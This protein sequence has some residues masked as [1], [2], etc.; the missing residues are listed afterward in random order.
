[1]AD[2]KEKVID[3]H[4]AYPFGKWEQDFMKNAE[5]LGAFFKASY[6]G[7]SIPAGVTADTVVAALKGGLRGG[8]NAKANPPTVFDPWNGWWCGEWSNKVTY[9]HIWDATVPYGKEYIQPVTQSARAFVHKGNLK[10]Q[11][12]DLDLAINVAGPKGITGWV[13]KADG[14]HP[15]VGYLLMKNVLLWITQYD[16]QFFMFL[17][18]VEGSTYKIQGRVFQLLKDEVSPMG[19]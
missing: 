19:D 10:D 2:F 6:G 14:D 13:S 1:M 11:G 5:K 17:E 9:Y 18:W 12:K 3:P 8:A 15:H 4:D 16:G 7:A